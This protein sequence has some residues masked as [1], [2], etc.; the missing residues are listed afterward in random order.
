[1]CASVEVG[2]RL[3]VLTIGTKL[4]GGSMGAGLAARR[5]KKDQRERYWDTVSAA[6]PFVDFKRIFNF[7]LPRIHIF[8]S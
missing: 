7:L 1:M 5:L 2:D 8:D 6:M 3:K 4:W